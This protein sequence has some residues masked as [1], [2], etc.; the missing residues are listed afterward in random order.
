V[1]KV[2]ET[3]VKEIEVAKVDIKD[4]LPEPE[5]TTEESIQS[6]MAEE[7]KEETKEEAKEEPKEEKSEEKAPERPMRETVS[8]PKIVQPLS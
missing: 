5:A 2:Q 7:N 6:N 3:T 4:T 1:V 8:I